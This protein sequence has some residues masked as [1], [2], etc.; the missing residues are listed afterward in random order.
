MKK[1]SCS[2]LQG[3]DKLAQEL[4]EKYNNHIASKI[5][6]LSGNCGSGKSYV[7]KQIFQKLKKCSVYINRGDEFVTNDKLKTIS[8]NSFSFSIGLASF[9]G[10][11]GVGF[12]NHTPQ[13]QYIKKILNCKNP[14]LFCIDNFS[15]A[16]PTIKSFFKKIIENIDSINKEVTHP[17]YFLITDY[18]CNKLENQFLN[19]SPYIETIE[20][21]PY[22]EK[23]IVEYLKI[24]HIPCLVT[25]EAKEKINN[26]YKICNGNLSL[27]DFL[28]VDIQIQ[29]SSYFKALEY[30]V[31]FRLESLKTK[32]KEKNIDEFEMEDIILSSALCIKNF[33]TTDIAQITY[34]NPNTVANSLNIAKNDIII[35]KNDD[36]S[37]VF[38]CQEIQSIL[39]K[40][41]L[42]KCKERLL[43]Y[44]KYYT[45]NEQDEYYNRAYYLIKY[46]DKIIPQAFSLLILSYI[47]SLKLSDYN[48]I[49]KT[50]K[51]INKSA[52]NEQKCLFQQIVSFCASMRNDNAIENLYQQYNNIIDNELELP[53]LG[54]ISNLF[55]NYIYRK[56]LPHSSITKDILNKC[57]QYALNPI[58]LEY[59]SN[60]IGLENNDE[61][62]IR[63]SIIYS[64]SPYILDV[65]NDIE[66]FQRLLNMSKTLSLN[67]KTHKTKGL[68]N[69][70][71]NVFNRKAFLF[72]NQTQCGIFYK[73]A[74]TFFKANHLW[75][76]YCITLVNEAGTEIVIQNYDN[77]IKNCKKAIQ[78][79]KEQ[80]LTLPQIAKL[81]NNLLI[82]RFLKFENNTNDLLKCKTMARKTYKLLIKQLK[83]IPCATEFVLITNIC[84]LSLYS[85]DEDIYLKYKERLEELMECKDVSNVLDMDVD[86]YYRYYFAWFEIYKDIKNGLWENASNK[87]NLIDAFVPTLFK[88]QEI[89]WEKKDKALFEIINN[90]TVIDPYEFCNR[91]VKTERRETILSK[92]FFRGLML[93][94]L[95][96]TSLQ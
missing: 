65:Q 28:F 47:S 63:L 77:A 91:L 5:T 46:F 41:G 25:D 35:D 42:N 61:T 18:P 6:L 56:Y 95:Q 26:V 14:V 2:T 53:A 7:I 88:K 74:L 62:I 30:I 82:A 60:P 3:R 38:H 29:S 68:A 76:D 37:F 32:G 1:Y 96:Y 59:I 52:S 72:A 15:Q 73:K 44:Y 24:R 20:L 39:S 75:L 55:F 12:Q 10:G 33:T 4:I 89:F 94:D 22:N 27:V 8:L 13:Y 9:S 31:S 93:S 70:V 21:L 54:E 43:Y 40:Y 51:L 45:E 84:S 16:S 49:E 57:L 81:F 69:Y 17:I 92:F 48:T 58:P 34:R 23:D 86:D 66:L 90:K 78:I 71:E 79:A 80:Q 11:L 85:D 19:L 36:C 83:D 64:I 87:A 67:A 50:I